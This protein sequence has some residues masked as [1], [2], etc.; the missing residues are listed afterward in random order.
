[1]KINLKQKIVLL[2]L[3]ITALATTSVFAD[4][5][6]PEPKTSVYSPLPVVV[7]SRGF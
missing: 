1:M 3:L 2:T 6:H 5:Q 4:N 7:I